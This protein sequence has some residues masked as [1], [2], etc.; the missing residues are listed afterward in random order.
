MAS[1][2]PTF[3]ARRGA[4]QHVVPDGRTRSICAGQMHSSVPV[5]ALI[6]S[7]TLIAG[8]VLCGCSSSLKPENAAAGSSSELALH[9]EPQGNDLRL[10]W[11]RHA[12]ILANARAAFSSLRTAISLNANCLS[13]PPSCNPA[14]CFTSQPATT[15]A[16][17]LTLR[18]PNPRRSLADSW[19]TLI[20]RTAFQPRCL[21][22]RHRI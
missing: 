5:F 9:A 13:L 6:R 14:A 17:A 21:R 20:A 19:P 18:P 10:T 2:L 15:F 11:N 1:S 4:V 7:L 12:P 3:R 22:L 16:F 8:L